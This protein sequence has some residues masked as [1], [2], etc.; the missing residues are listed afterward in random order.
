LDKKDITV[1]GEMEKMCLALLYVRAEHFILLLKTVFPLAH[2]RRNIAIDEP[3]PV[4]VHF[5]K[6]NLVCAEEAANAL[7]NLHG[8]NIY[9]SCCT[10]RLV[11]ALISSCLALVKMCFIIV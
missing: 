5:L 6:V 8:C 10:L 11:L 7:K 4:P 2:C 9:P 3:L 1:F